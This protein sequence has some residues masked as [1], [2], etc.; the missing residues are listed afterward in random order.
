MPRSPRRYRRCQTLLDRGYPNVLWWRDLG[1]DPYIRNDKKGIYV[2]DADG[3]A[4]TA[5]KDKMEDM[6][7]G[8]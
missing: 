8:E 3:V 2:V 5:P 7:A 1:R 6:D 4:D